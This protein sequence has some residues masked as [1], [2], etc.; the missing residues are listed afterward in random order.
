[1]KYR[2]FT[3]RYKIKSHSQRFITDR[4]QGGFVLAHIHY[5]SREMKKC[6]ISALNHRP[7][8]IPRAIITSLE[9]EQLP[10]SKSKDLH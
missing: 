7:A 3:L 6:D 4:T 1:M 2:T 5:K 10:K 9:D 8:L